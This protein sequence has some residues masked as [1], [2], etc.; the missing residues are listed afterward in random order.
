MLNLADMFHEEVGKDI[1]A[2]YLQTRSDY[3]RVVRSWQDYCDT[4]A[5]STGSEAKSPWS[6][7]QFTQPRTA[8]YFEH[9]YEPWTH[10]ADGVAYTV[11]LAR[12]VIP[13]GSQGIIRLLN[14][15]VSGDY[16]VSDNW[17]NPFTGAAPDVYLWSLRLQPV[18]TL[19]AMGGRL[20]TAQNRYPGLPYQDLPQWQY[21]WYMP[22][23][24]GANVN[25]VIP[26]GYCVRY[27]VRTDA[28]QASNE[29]FGRIAGYWQPSEYNEHATRNAAKGF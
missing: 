11:E 26:G 15:W 3:M 20:I 25:L 5:A 18:D 1:Q 13:Y 24:P 9:F 2:Q 4:V 10:P 21:L 23:S 16:T 12:F 8:R 19:Q 7:Q 17:G 28:S 14:Q 22:H 27:F 6:Q 29:V